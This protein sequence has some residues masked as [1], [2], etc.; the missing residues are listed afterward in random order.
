MYIHAA[1][2]FILYFFNDK[3]KLLRLFA[4]FLYVKIL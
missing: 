2:M 1:K 3:N 4:T